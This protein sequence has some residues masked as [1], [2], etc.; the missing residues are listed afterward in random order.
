MSDN[1][2]I[3]LVA[4]GGHAFMQSGE[5]GTIEDHV[6]PAAGTAA[7]VTRLKASRPPSAIPTAARNAASAPKTAILL[8][9][10]RLTTTRV[11]TFS[12]AILNWA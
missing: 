3:V 8:F 9:S 4:M 6:R 1:R 7:S 2:P 5:S 11:S 12:K 10:K